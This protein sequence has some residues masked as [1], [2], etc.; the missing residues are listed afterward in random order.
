M[1]VTRTW[2]HQKFNEILKLIFQ[3]NEVFNEKE[4]EKQQS[5]LLTI[6]KKMMVASLINISLLLFWSSPFIIYCLM[7][8]IEAFF[9]Q[10]LTWYSL[11]IMIIVSVAFYF[12]SSIS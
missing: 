1:L 10:I 3:L 6:S 7:I 9:N 11:T 5:L 12:K 2:K 4:D 8:G